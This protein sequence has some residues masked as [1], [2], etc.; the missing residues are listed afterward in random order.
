MTQES[1]TLRHVILQPNK[2]IGAAQ[3]KETEKA[4]VSNERQQIVDTMLMAPS[5]TPDHAS[6]AGGG[7]KSVP[8]LRK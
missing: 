5:D 6:D 8:S 1:E 7:K 2:L 4:Q 3:K